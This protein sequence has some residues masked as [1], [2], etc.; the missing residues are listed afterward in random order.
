MI[1]KEQNTT[2][3]RELS[4]ARQRVEELLRQLA[5]ANGKSTE[6]QTDVQRSFWFSKKY[7][8]CPTLI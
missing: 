7:M 5:D 3:G 1:E 6:L 4:E 8:I 2:T